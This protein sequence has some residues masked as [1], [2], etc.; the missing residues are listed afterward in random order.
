M[1]SVEV[2]K[3]TEQTLTL[4]NMLLNR[5]SIELDKAKPENAQ[6]K[7]SQRRCGPKQ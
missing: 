6:L 3:Q 1:S 4:T 5:N 2:R 7:Q